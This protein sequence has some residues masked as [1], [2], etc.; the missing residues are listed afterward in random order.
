MFCALSKKATFLTQLG[1][2][3]SGP[4][5][6]WPSAALKG[7]A[8]IT[9]VI[10]AHELS[11]G[12]CRIWELRKS[13]KCRDL[14][15]P[16]RSS[17]SPVSPMIKICK[18]LLSSRVGLLHASKQL[19]YDSWIS[20]LGAMLQLSP[21]DALCLVQADPQMIDRLM[22]PLCRPLSVLV[23]LI[24]AAE[25]YGDSELRK[26]M[27]ARLYLM[28]ISGRVRV[29]ARGEHTGYMHTVCRLA[30]EMAKFGE[31]Q[32]QRKLATAPA[33]DLCV[34]F[35]TNQGVF[36]VA[37]EAI[38]AIAHCRDDTDEQVVEDARIFNAILDSALSE[39]RSQN[40]YPRVTLALV[41]TLSL[42]S[43]SQKLDA[44]TISKIM[45]LSEERWPVAQ[46]LLLHELIQFCELD[47]YQDGHLAGYGRGRFRE[48]LHRVLTLE[49]P[50]N[51]TELVLVNH[52]AWLIFHQDNIIADLAVK[53]LGNAQKFPANV[54]HSIEQGC[55][56]ILWLAASA[57]E[58][59]TVRR[60]CSV[61]VALS[62]QR[63]F[64]ADCV[65]TSALLSR[66]QSVPRHGVVWWWERNN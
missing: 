13:C 10:A 50:H 65:S 19:N 14:A 49:I 26:T 40:A 20:I 8:G 5:I 51:S 23:Q 63:N 57:N 22:R 18:F 61:C 35:C 46:G 59:V 7:V 9:L 16:C 38:S 64:L 15:K 29:W 34:T 56:P 37:C 31:S 11:A 45:S 36:Q 33:V 4:G 24:I 55:V 28:N 1:R 39:M 54:C 17:G 53:C 2:Y 52:L 43:A 60:K 44:Q 32:G 62:N 42:L 58:I 21:R 27:S 6:S 30:C 41:M 3:P 48:G 25:T 66:E 47:N 12:H